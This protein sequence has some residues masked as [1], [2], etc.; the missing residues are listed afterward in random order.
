[1]IPIDVEF[2]RQFARDR[3]QELRRDYRRVTATAARGDGVPAAQ[4]LR[5]R[6]VASL[7]RR[8]RRHPAAQLNG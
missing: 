3:I 1:M 4:R 5:T 2:R 7:L 6:G 8:R